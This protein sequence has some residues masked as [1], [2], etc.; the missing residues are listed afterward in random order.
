LLEPTETALGQPYRGDEIPSHP[1]AGRGLR[2]VEK[3]KSITAQV[4]DEAPGLVEE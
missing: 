3:E 4:G 2:K 1:E